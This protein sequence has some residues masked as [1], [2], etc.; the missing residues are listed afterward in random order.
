MRDY[1][2]EVTY[3]VLV[4]YDIS[5]NK[6]RLKISKYLESYG[7]R[8]QKSCFEA[9]LSKKKYE[10]MISDLEK[11]V[12]EEE[13]IRIYRIRSYEEIRLIGSKDY[14]QEEDIIII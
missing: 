6:R 3:I 8:V 1:G 14:S 13:N 2:N 4:I 10:Q 5:D 9:R 12:T 11:M 7:H